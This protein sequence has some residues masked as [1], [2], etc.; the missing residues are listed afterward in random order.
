[1][2]GDLASVPLS[3]A[4][5]GQAL[6]HTLAFILLIAGMLSAPS[7]AEEA[8]PGTAVSRFLAQTNGATG[9]WF[10]LSG[11]LK[12]YGL[13]VTGEAKELFLGQLSGGLP[14]QARGN[15]NGEVKMK[16][17]YD[18]QPLFGLKGLTIE[19]NWRDRYGGNPQFA[20]GTYNL[21][22]PTVL[23]ANPGLRI[24]TQQIEYST[25]DKAFRLNVGWENPYEQFLQ[26]PLSKFFENT[27]ITQ[28]KGIGGQ[29]GP[30]I[31]VVNP[32]ASAGGSPPSA[33][34]P[35][36][37]G[38]YAYRSSPVPWNSSYAAWGGTLKIKPVKN[39][40]LQSGL[41]LAI[42]G[43][44]GTTPSQYTPT[45]VYPYTSV[46]KSYLGTI[47][48]SGQIV[49]FVDGTGKVVPHAPQNMGWIP[50][51]QNN[52]GFNFQGSPKFTPNTANLGRG[53]TSAANERYPTSRNAQGQWVQGSRYNYASPYD[54][55]NGGNSSQNGIYNVNEIGW[56]PKIGKDRLEGK[57][58]LGSYLWGQK[59]TSFM[60]TAFTPSGTADVSYAARKPVAYQENQVL[61][62]LYLQAD[63]QLFR[64]RSEEPGK[65]S[66]QGL[67]NFNEF[68][69][70]PPQNNQLPFYFQ[71]G[72]VYRGLIPHRNE[73]SL[74]IA[75]GAGFYSSYYNQW[76][77]SQNEQLQFNYGTPNNAP[78]PD[79]PAQ[80]QPIGTTNSS[81]TRY[82]NGTAKGTKTPSSVTQ[83]Q[84]ATPLKDTYA[85]LPG[86][87]ST[88]VIEAFYNIQFTPW[89]ALKPSV[90][91]IINP[92]GNGTVQDDWILGVTA[93]VTF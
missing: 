39:V 34:N 61:W 71:T 24:L 81:S 82:V 35:V 80:Y 79:G 15:W 23:N 60:P 51:Y 92:A 84:Q 26:Q 25:E 49:P 17:L 65:L 7:H 36:Y 50:G 12:S 64:E 43:T 42:S 88:E 33:K 76:V 52:H 91:Y 54:A 63:Q 2:T 6:S 13:S 41:Y 90:Q 11:P 22:N 68:T 14:N 9:G 69:F 18:F 78:I 66:R 56:E 83:Q 19:S 8:N 74:G 44:G 85:Y 55:G 28:S 40:Y 86:F 72:L 29:A 67:Y 21:F 38:S 46:P 73:D 5:T 3:I 87:T 89:A 10:G 1:M 70:T 58:A 27:M 30:G 59:N 77:Q 4:R 57:Y 20:A 47:R 45:S 75:L 48:Q 53:A 32:S 62:G 93:K 31:V 37:Q 16:F